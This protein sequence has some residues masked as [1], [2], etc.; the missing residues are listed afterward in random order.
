MCIKYLEED[1]E[2]SKDSVSVSSDCHCYCF[3]D[4]EGTESPLQPAEYPVG[5]SSECKTR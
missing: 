2:F 1:Q 3:T 5:N 4:T